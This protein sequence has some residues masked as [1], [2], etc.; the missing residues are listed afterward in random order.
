VKKRRS[1]NHQNNHLA[2]ANGGP[3][4]LSVGLCNALIRR[5]CFKTKGLNR[6]SGI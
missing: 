3:E 4:P 6:I 5:S 1:E 2:E